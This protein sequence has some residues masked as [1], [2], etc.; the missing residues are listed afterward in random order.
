MSDDQISVTYTVDEET[1]MKACHAVWSQQAIGRRGNVVVGAVMVVCGLC[2]VW[3]Q[4]PWYYAAI[5]WACAVFMLLASTIRNVLWRRYYRRLEKYKA[6]ITTTLGVDGFEVALNGVP[7]LVPWSTFAGHMKTDDALIMTAI[8]RQVSVIPL[9]SFDR[10]AQAEA[11]AQM[12]AE[13]VPLIRK[14]RL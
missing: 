5:V 9:A 4:V 7:A 3:I 1:F 14:R 8:N 11:F 6:P 10:P 12:V 2:M 13:N